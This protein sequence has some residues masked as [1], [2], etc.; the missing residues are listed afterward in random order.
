MRIT[1]SRQLENLWNALDNAEGEAEETASVA[2]RENR[3]LS[4]DLWSLGY[5]IRRLQGIVK[6]LQAAEELPAG[7]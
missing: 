3:P 1:L 6:R 7:V 2:Y 5:E 4:D